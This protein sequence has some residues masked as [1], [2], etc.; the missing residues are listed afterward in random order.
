MKNA[1]TITVDHLG[2]RCSVTCDGKEVDDIKSISIPK[3]SRESLHKGLTVMIEVIP[4]RVVVE[5]DGSTLA[6]CTCS[7]EESDEMTR[8]A[9]GCAIVKAG[10]GW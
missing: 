6:A 8:H 9:S 1:L 3:I 7:Y 5:A 4:E 2:T 10:Q